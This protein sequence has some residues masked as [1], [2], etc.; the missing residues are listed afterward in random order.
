ML[1]ERTRPDLCTVA[2]PVSSVNTP[3]YL[4][5][6][7]PRHKPWDQHRAEADEV[8]RVFDGGT[9]RHQRYAE[10]VAACSQVLEF[11]RDPPGANRSKLKLKHVWFCRVRSC[12]VC[13]WRRALCWQARVYLCLPRLM[14]DY[15]D[16]KFLFLTLTIRNCKIENLRTTLKLLADGWKRLTELREWPARGWVRSVEI[17]R[18][19]D[20]SAHPHYHCLLVVPPAYF[21]G[22]YLKQKQWALLWKQC[23]R[24]NYHPVVDIRVVKPEQRHASGEITPAT[25]N[26]WGAVVEIL[27]YAV[28]PS[29]MIRDHDWF[30]Q[31]TDQ[32]HKTR[33]VA[34]GG[35][36]KRYIREQKREDLTSE[37]GEEQPAGK[38]EQVFFGWKRH[39]LRY[40]RLRLGK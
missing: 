19:K 35:I 3:E 6:V 11:A 4:S 16:V 8:Q 23:L 13:Q 26:I 28:K 24:I 29:D 2:I 34:V 38:A 12:P 7:S 39:V 25:W 9:D 32:I 18:G 22:D 14:K 15:P 10:R 5:D 36:L 40:Q 30:L 17:T 20:G 31:L 21:Q 37:P 27:K 1:S 33:A